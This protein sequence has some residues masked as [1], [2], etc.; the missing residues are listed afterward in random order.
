MTLDR[1]L[2]RQFIPIFLSALAL[3]I[4]LVLLIDLFLNLT[5]YLNAGAELP[6]ILKVS[7]Y[8]I[9]K[10]INYALP[11]SLLF[12]SAYTLGDLSAKNELTTILGSGLPFWRFC[13]SLIIIGIFASIF[14]FFFEDK[15]VIPS[16]RRKNELSRELLQTNTENLSDIVIKINGGRLIYSVDYYDASSLSINGVT[17]IELD[18]NNRLLS[19]VYAVK[20]IWTG[21][22]WSFSNPLIYEW[23]EGFLKPH[24]AVATE[25]YNEDPET[26]RRSSVFPGDLNAKDAA[27]LIKDLKRAGLPVASALADYHHRFS[28]SAVSF[29]VIFLSLTMSGRFK[30]NI[31]L[32]SLLASLGT[33]SIYYVIEMLSMM[34]AK[35]GILPPF[36]GAWIPIF[37]CTLAGFVLLRITKT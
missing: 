26:F 14:S 16:F 5:K 8:Y 31:L 27:A 33:A 25:K 29:V 7:L 1:Y 6:A 34:S 4:M 30:K 10:S 3:F 28:F 11:V 32:L 17:I 18:E 24:T 36:W 35:V 2:V 9:P 12:A 22:S 23:D 21:N 37:V 20:A 15:A 13:L 19:M